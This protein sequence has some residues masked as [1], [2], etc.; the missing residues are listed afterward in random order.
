MSIPERSPYIR[1][2]PGAATLDII[3]KNTHFPDDLLADTS[4]TQCQV[5]WK[6]RIPVLTFHFKSPVYDF[7][8][9]LVP[10]ELK[11]AEPGWV[12][13]PRVIVRLLLA[14]TTIADD[15]TEREFVLSKDDSRS[16]KEVLG[17]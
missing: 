4:Q 15:V 9:P 16:L 7:S 1:V 17:V 10:A 8:E 3:L 11:N 6:E 14:N 2:L 5:K 12:D 13:Q